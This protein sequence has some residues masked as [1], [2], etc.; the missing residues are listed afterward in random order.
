MGEYERALG[1]LQNLLKFFEER[2]A[3]SRSVSNG[4]MDALR[5]SFARRLSPETGRRGGGGARIFS[6]LCSRVLIT[7][8][9]AGRSGDEV[10]SL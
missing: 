8:R 5:Q 4:A 7:L 1:H 9:V 6:V 3:A 10:Y 2:A